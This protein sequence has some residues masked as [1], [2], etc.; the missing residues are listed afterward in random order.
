MPHLPTANTRPLLAVILLESGEA[1]MLDRC[2]PF[3]CAPPRA[4]LLPDPPRAHPRDP[5]MNI[6]IR[7]ALRAVV[8]VVF[9]PL[10]LHFMYSKARNARRERDAKAGQAF[11]DGLRRNAGRRQ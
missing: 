9:L 2:S 11:I 3:S 6:F 8:E 10:R 7:F 4:H 5:P 1:S